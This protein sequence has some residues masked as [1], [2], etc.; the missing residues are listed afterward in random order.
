[1][2]LTDRLSIPVRVVFARRREKVPAVAAA[3]AG[4]F[5]NVLVTDVDTAAALIAY[6]S[7][8]RASV[9]RANRVRLWHTREVYPH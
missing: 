2:T 7:S 8:S 9:A 4:R 1:M 3:L 6:A 5:A